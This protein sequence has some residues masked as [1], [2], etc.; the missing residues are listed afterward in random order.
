MLTNV[1][2]SDKGL[3]VC[4]AAVTSSRSVDS[5]DSQRDSNTNAL[6]DENDENDNEN[7]NDNDKQN[8]ER[9]EHEV[10]LTSTTETNNDTFLKP[11]VEN[12][13]NIKYQI[14][15][16]T[17]AK[18]NITT[19][20]QNALTTSMLPMP[21]ITTITNKTST[22]KTT[23]TLSTIIS[24]SDSASATATASSITTTTIIITTIT[25]HTSASA[26]INNTTTTSY[27]SSNRSSSSAS[28]NSSLNSN[29]LTPITATVSTSI[30]D[31][32]EEQEFQAFQK[33][34]LTVR[35]PPGP[36]T[37]LYFKASTILGFLIWRFNKTNSGGYPV[38]SFTAE[39]RNVS[40]AT[41]PFNTSFEHKWSRMDPINIAPN[42]VSKDFNCFFFVIPF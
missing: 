23:P 7:D 25:N 1:S 40:Y 20:T 17:T 38:R 9:N 29:T 41:P 14:I 37:K 18:T 16:A 8:D 36:V 32:I 10:L 39:F 12:K 30:M 11:L 19:K 21:N 2:A 5:D 3:Y 34:N 35:T 24:A 31:D 22:A 28:S 26:N 27:I 4:F 13:K 15:N 42:V 6:D 33:I